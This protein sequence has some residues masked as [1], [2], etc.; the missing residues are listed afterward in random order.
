MNYQNN[1]I[2]MWNKFYKLSEQKLYVLYKSYELTEQIC[3]HVEPI[4]QTHETKF[5]GFLTIK[6][7][8]QDTTLLCFDKRV[9]IHIFKLRLYI[10]RNT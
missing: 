3:I 5:I 6:P 8:Q 10:W 1:Y 7:S 2:Y 9:F 4:L